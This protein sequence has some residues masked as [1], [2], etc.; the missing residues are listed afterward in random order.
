[1]CVARSDEFRVHVFPRCQ[2]GVHPHFSVIFCPNHPKISNIWMSQ[3]WVQTT[4]LYALKQ[5]AEMFIT[6][7]CMELTCPWIEFSELRRFWQIIHQPENHWRLSPFG[8]PLISHHSSAIK[9]RSYYNS[10]SLLADTA[11]IV[12]ILGIS[13]IK[14]YRAMKPKT[15]LYNKI[16][17][18]CC[19]PSYAWHKGWIGTLYSW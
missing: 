2:G 18:G 10:T 12:N 11:R 5:I 3:N 14:S 19:K 16:R 13:I 17:T 1:M 9:A 8:V 6:N 7:V 15:G 4:M